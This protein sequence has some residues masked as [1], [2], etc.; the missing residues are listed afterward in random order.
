MK[1]ILKF[2][3]YVVLFSF[4]LYFIVIVFI[5]SLQ[6]SI[7]SN[8]LSPHFK[9]VVTSIFPESFAFFTKDP[10][11]EQVVLYSVQNTKIDKIN[12]KTNSLYNYFGFSRNSRRLVYEIGILAKK[13]PDSLWDDIEE[14]DIK[15]IDFKDVSPFLIETDD[16]IQLF[17]KGEYVF[18]YYK[19]IPWEW[20]DLKKETNGKYVYVS[21]E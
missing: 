1:V 12:L 4:F 10:K 16:H 9:Y 14:N 17:E 7:L 11:D 15:N 3:S 6:I 19:T 21:I 8:A 5:S 20:N 18:Y 2:T 13:I